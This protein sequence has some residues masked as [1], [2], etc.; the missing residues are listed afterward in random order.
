MLKKYIE[1]FLKEHIY[2]DDRMNDLRVIVWDAFVENN[3]IEPLLSGITEDFFSLSQFK[4]TDLQE[5]L[6]FVAVL[7]LENSPE[8]WEVTHYSGFVRKLPDGSL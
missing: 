2:E 1:E 5:K 3:S 7:E 4:Y 6:F 8:R